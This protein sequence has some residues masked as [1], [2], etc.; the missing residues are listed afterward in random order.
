[1]V[2]LQ[3]QIIN[4][5]NIVYDY[6]LMNI[7]FT[8]I[9]VIIC[10]F[11]DKNKTVVLNKSIYQTCKYFFPEILIIIFLLGGLIIAIIEYN[12]IDEKTK[13]FGEVFFLKSFYKNLFKINQ[14]FLFFFTFIFFYMVNF[15]FTFHE[16]YVVL[17]NGYIIIDKYTIFIK[18][19]ISFFVLAVF[20]IN[21]EY[22]SC[23]YTNILEYF[24]ILG[25]SILFLF[26]LVSS[27]HLMTVYLALEGLGLCII[28]II[29]M[30]DSSEKDCLESGKKY[31]IIAA[32]SSCFLAFSIVLLYLFL[33]HIDF[34]SLRIFF[35]IEA[36]FFGLKQ[37]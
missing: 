6:Y 7:H 13:I 2:R 8:Y 24:F 20:I 17:F 10:L 37:F 31:F 21:K 25:F 30:L 9:I 4:F 19:L 11:I 28:I 35:D 27:F 14:A 3:N 18:L 23:N 12:Y 33:G 16:N 29:S 36:Y 32:M 26:L 1:M 15:F 22:I 34:L 5:L